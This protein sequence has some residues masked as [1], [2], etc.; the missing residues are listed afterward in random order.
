MRRRMKK[1]FG[2]MRKSRQKSKAKLTTGLVDSCEAFLSDVDEKNV[3]S[4]DKKK[5][6]A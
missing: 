6:R 4:F 1:H 3:F 2:M 5:K